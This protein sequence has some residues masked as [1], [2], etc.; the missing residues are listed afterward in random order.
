MSRRA[1]SGSLASGA[2]ALRQRGVIER[3]DGDDDVDDDHEEA[4]EVIAL[5]V[6][7]EVSDRDDGE[8]E[9]DEVEDVEVEAHGELHPPPDDDDKGTVEEG[10]LQSRAQD[11]RQCEVHLVV[12]CLVDGRD[13]LGC[14]LHE[15]DEDQAH[16]GVRDAVVFDDVVD[17]VHQGY[18]D[19][20]DQCDPVWHRLV[21]NCRFLAKVSR[22]YRGV[23]STYDTTSATMH[24][25]SVSFAL[26]ASLWASWSR[27][28]S[29]SNTA[30]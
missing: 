19:E 13:V 25:V 23:E 11:V 20:G 4:L 12:P 22:A 8:D 24:S 2:P 17:L 29:Y 10:R 1:L 9:H 3:G 14:F 15:R 28:S 5:L 18:G 30:S 7:Q 21:T 26:W 6:A 16:E 27:S